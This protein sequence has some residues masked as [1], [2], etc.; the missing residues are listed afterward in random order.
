VGVNI[1]GDNFKDVTVVTVR[2]LDPLQ[3]SRDECQHD[4]SDLWS[5][6]YV[7]MGFAGATT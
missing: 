2:A 3:G 1:F 5:H 7:F 6:T 4:A